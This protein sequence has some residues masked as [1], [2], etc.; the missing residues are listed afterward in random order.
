MPSMKFRLCFGLASLENDSEK[1]AFLTDNAAFQD[2]CNASQNVHVYP[3]G[4]LWGKELPLGV[5]EEDARA[6]KS[7]LLAFQMKHR[8]G[9]SD[10]IHFQA[11]KRVDSYSSGRKALATIVD[12]FMTRG[13]VR[14]KIEALL[15]ENQ[16]HPLTLRKQAGVGGS[17]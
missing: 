13:R 12:G 5:K 11:E 1:G 10:W 14:E 9:D 2:I 15:T 6:M 7:Y 3:L 16:L 4:G 17:Q 8:S